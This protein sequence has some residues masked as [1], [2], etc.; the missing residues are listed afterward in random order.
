MFIDINSTKLQSKEVLGGKGFGLWEMAQIG[1]PVPQAFVLPTSACMEYRTDAKAFMKKVAKALPALYAQFPPGTLLSVRSGARVSMP[2]MMDTI[3]NVGMSMGDMDEWAKSLGKECASKCYVSLCR[4][5]SELV[6]ADKLPPEDPLQQLYNA[7]EMVLV[8]W[9]NPRAATYR[10]MYNIP[11]SWGTAVIIQAMVFGNRNDKSAT[12]VLFSR[13]ADT[14]IN[15]YVVDWLPCQQGE[16]VVAGTHNTLGW[17][18]L[19]KWNDGIAAELGLIADK[20]EDR[21]KDAQD[22][23]WTVDNGKLYILQTRVAKRTAQAAVAIA[24]D[25]VNEGLITKQD[26]FY[27]I[28]RRDFYLATVPVVDPKFKDKPMWVGKPASSGV[29]TGKVVFT[30][31]DAID[32]KVPCILVTEETNPDDIGGMDAAVGVL[33]MKGGATSHAAVVARGMN[34]PCVVGL[35]IKLNN[36]ELLN[37]NDLIISMCGATGRVWITA[38][39]VISGASTAVATFEQWM[40]DHLG[41]LPINQGPGSPLLL[42]LSEEAATDLDFAVDC[43]RAAVAAGRNVLVKLDDLNWTKEEEVFY[44]GMGIDVDAAASAIPTIL[45]H[46]LPTK[47]HDKVQF[48]GADTG[49]L[50]KEVPQLK[51]LQDAV[52]ATADGI[53]ACSGDIA[54]SKVVEWQAERGVKLRTLGDPN[55]SQP[56]LSR[57]QVVGQMLG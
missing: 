38:V 52:L 37:G 2:G 40:F 54:L 9:D 19:A 11:Y 12:G 47:D 33:T 55:A 28:S 13:D 22:I 3:L 27:R 36:F 56:I 15:E 26:A 21:Y 41:A 7:I 10:K 20:L 16:A 1:L 4:Q 48:L 34:K 30:A 49:G 50:F 44:F 17:A 53:V 31:Q 14:G 57:E 35:G 42:D 29:V 46:E 39:P 24:V 51:S 32:C 6:E 18:A 43:I 45:Y 8:S 23:E 25:M 5:W